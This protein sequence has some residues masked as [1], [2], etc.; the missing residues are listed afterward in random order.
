MLKQYCIGPQI[1][2]SFEVFLNLVELTVYQYQLW[3]WFKIV[4][5]EYRCLHSCSFHLKFKNISQLK[6]I[7]FAFVLCLCLR[8]LC[9]NR[10][11]LLYGH[12]LLGGNSI[13][14]CSC[15]YKL[16]SLLWS[17]FRLNLYSTIH[18]VVSKYEKLRNYVNELKM[19]F[20]SCNQWMVHF[21]LSWFIEN[22]YFIK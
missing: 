9:R 14:V 6:L 16:C 3:L 20:C 2:W 4:S 11:F 22:L 1:S 13:W 21:S 15:K 18:Y 10:Y 8:I 17:T 12:K 19:N 5:A 7:S